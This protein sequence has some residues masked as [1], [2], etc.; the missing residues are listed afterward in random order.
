MA[1]ERPLSKLVPVL[2]AIITCDTAVVDPGTGEKE[3]YRDFRPCF[4]DFSR[5]AAGDCI[6]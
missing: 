2:L 5:T 4:R 1:E 3:P 6:C